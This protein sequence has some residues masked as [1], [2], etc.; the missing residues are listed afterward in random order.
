MSNKSCYLL[1]Q[2]EGEETLL[3]Y[4]CVCRSHA[5]K[6]NIVSNNHGHTY[7]CDFSVLDRKYG[8]WANLVKRKFGSQTNSNMQNSLVLTFSVLDRKHPFWGQ[9]WSKNQICQF[10]LKFGT[11]TNLNMQNSVVLF[12]FSVSGQKHPFWAKLLQNVKIVSLS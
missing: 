11:Q 5:E 4:C 6:L 12:T 2:L 3:K 1:L 7:K 10:K 8:F 9:I